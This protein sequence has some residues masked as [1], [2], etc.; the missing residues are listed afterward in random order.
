MALVNSSPFE[1]VVVKFY[2]VCVVS[3]S[4]ASG[5]G[6]GGGVQLLFK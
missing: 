2:D 1:K 6:G 3:L 5:G 4:V